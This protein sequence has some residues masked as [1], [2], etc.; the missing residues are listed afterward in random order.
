MYQEDEILAVIDK[1]KK[2]GQDK[3]VEKFDFFHD[4]RVRSVFY[5]LLMV[6]TVGWVAW[7]LF[8]G[9]SQNLEV[10]GMK[11][12]FSFLGVEAGF[13]TDFKLIEYTLGKGTYGDIF[14][15]CILKTLYISALAIIG[16]T[17]LG[18]T[19]GVLRLSNNW[20]VS[21]VALT[22]VEIFRNTPLLV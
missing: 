7:Y 5:Q 3:S 8:T 18:F 15:I 6:A 16:S 1:L 21:K 2:S 13:G 10:R 22:F 9:T 17:I 20:L 14:L 19:V 4:E 12:G 11:S